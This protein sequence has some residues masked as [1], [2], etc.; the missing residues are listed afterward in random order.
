MKIWHVYSL[1]R[2]VDSFNPTLGGDSFIFWPE[3]LVTKYLAFRA[4]KIRTELLFIPDSVDERAFL[5]DANS[6]NLQYE[7]QK[8]GK[9]ELKLV[10]NFRFYYGSSVRAY[11]PLFKDVGNLFE[12]QLECDRPMPT[13]GTENTVVCGDGKR[14]LR[15]LVTPKKNR[16]PKDDV[17]NLSL[18]VR[19]MQFQIKYAISR[20]FRDVL[21]ANNISGIK[22]TP[23]LNGDLSWSET[24][25]QFEYSDERVLEASQYFQLSITGETAPVQTSI[26]SKELKLCSVCNLA[27]TWDQYKSL[28]PS[29]QPANFLN[30]LDFQAERLLCTTDGKIAS[31]WHSPTYYISA[32]VVQIII[33]EKITGFSS[34]GE[35]YGK[36]LPVLIEGEF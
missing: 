34:A 11:S 4:G 12:K 30:Q 10:S 22:L 26:H 23:I 7:F 36:F 18:L 28:A 6:I 32:K 21:I 24:E 5:C 20:R 9:W 31:F 25:M 17:F 33:D 29:I 35:R 13:E 1:K 8:I 19:E 2:T 15:K 3:W 14:Q 27:D 16:F